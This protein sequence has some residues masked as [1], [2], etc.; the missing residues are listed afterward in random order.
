MTKM[1]ARGRSAANRLKIR[2]RVAVRQVGPVLQIAAL[3]DH[4]PLSS[5]QGKALARYCG[6][7]HPARVR[8]SE[9]TVCGWYG[10]TALGELVLVATRAVTR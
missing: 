10:A 3:P 8:I 1:E 6:V 5:K 9:G 2:G 4:H 7:S